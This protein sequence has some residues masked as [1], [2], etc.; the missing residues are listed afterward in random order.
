MPPLNVSAA[1]E[2]S[3]ASP[4]STSEYV[5]PDGRCVSSQSLESAKIFASCPPFLS[6]RSSFF[7]SPPFSTLAPLVVARVRT[8]TRSCPVNNRVKANVNGSRSEDPL[9]FT[10]LYLR[11]LLVEIARGERGGR[12]REVKKRARRR[13]TSCCRL[14]CIDL[15]RNERAFPLELTTVVIRVVASLRFLP[16]VACA[17]VSL[18]LPLENERLRCRSSERVSE[19][20]NERK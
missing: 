16:F 18:S 11:D 7:P 8:K 13:D 5:F 1:T 17:S 4:R 2:C 9:V 20:T 10:D 14:H 3:H 15:S 12:K 6:L 19:R